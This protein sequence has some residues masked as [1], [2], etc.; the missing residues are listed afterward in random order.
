MKRWTSRSLWISCAFAL[1]GSA[2]C[3]VEP[4]K[5][6]V[7]SGPRLVKVTGHV[8]VDGKPVDG[9]I[10]VF[11]PSFSESGTH[12]VG[13]T[14]EQGEYSLEHLGRKGTAAG[15]YRVT[16]SLQ[17]APDGRVLRAAERDAIVQS[18]DVLSAV[19]LVPERYSNFSKTEL[20]AVVSPRGDEINFELK[21][22]LREAPSPTTP[23]P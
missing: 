6:R 9:A 17:V 12:S 1:L 14:N 3:E 2:G 18:N 13:A 23:K 5:P 22:P 4:P 7:E 21:G 11:L 19:E 15:D 16:I 10:V 8:T 20:R